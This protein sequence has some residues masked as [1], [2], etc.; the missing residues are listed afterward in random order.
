M[1]DTTT[2]HRKQ[3]RSEGDLTKAHENKDKHEHKE[4]HHKEPHHKPGGKGQ[5]GAGHH[6]PPHGG[7][8]ISQHRRGRLD[9]DLDDDFHHSASSHPIR[10]R[11]DTMMSRGGHSTYHESDRRSV[12]TNELATPMVFYENTYK[13]TPDCRFHEGKV[14]DIIRTVL[15]ENITEKVYDPKM[16]GQK[17]QLISEIIK[18]RIKTLDMARFKI[19]CMV[20]IGQ[21]NDQSML[22]TSRCLWDHRFDNSISVEYKQG[23]IIAVG[24]VFAVYAE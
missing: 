5:H 22:V 8:R 10:P 24:L 23:D 19:V 4:V 6:G 17:C 9:H 16:C 3:S 15:K 7:R 1:K 18:E 20:M 2:A 11:R 21:V 14:R 13:L 12:G